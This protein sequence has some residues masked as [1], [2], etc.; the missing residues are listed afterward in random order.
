MHYG[1]YKNVRNASWQCLIDYNIRALPVKVM[2]IA[3]KS[4]ITVLKYS[5]VDKERLQYNES[6]A[7]F[8]EDN[9]IY[10][11]Y[12]D[13]ATIEHCR[14]TIAHELGHIFLGHSLTENNSFSRKFDTA[15]SEIEQEADVF[16]SRLLAPA[17]VLWGLNLHTPEGIAK[18]CNIS[19]PAAKIRSE[20]MD[21]LYKR[22]KFLISPLEQ[23]VYN[24]FSEFI[25]TFS[26]E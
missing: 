20:R 13:T 26:N 22:N 2:D 1:I 7:T 15:K 8:F 4:N 6:G 9:N 11:I 3:K 21:I 25:D 5:D 19:L 16:A 18:A 24:N 17:C 12:R 23:Q 14:F 10:V